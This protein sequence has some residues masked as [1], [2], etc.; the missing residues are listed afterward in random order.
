M[1][2][3]KCVQCGKEFV[4]SDSEKQ[5]FEN[6]N[7]NLPKRCKECREKNNPHQVKTKTNVVTPKKERTF[8]IKKTFRILFVC[9]IVFGI[10]YFKSKINTENIIIEQDATQN[11][12][13]NATLNATDD[14][15]QDVATDPTQ[16]INVSDSFTFKSESLLQEHFDKHGSEFEYTSPSQYEKGA[17]AVINS[18]E[19]LHKTEAEDGDNVYYIEATNELVILSTEGY[20]RTYFKPEDGIDYYNRQ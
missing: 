16:D 1:E 3:R 2:Q 6:R 8:S 7:L 13:Q 11:I 12:T 9:L 14:I 18:T 17:S 10:L 5:F 19:A 20:I 15:T 4:I